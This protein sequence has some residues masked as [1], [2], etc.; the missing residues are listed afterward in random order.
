MKPKSSNKSPVLSVKGGRQETPFI[1]PEERLRRIARL[2]VKA[3]YLRESSETEQSAQ[4]HGSPSSN[5]VSLD[6]IQP[7]HQD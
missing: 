4:P 7:S 3:I 5:S 2:L 1:T 6:L